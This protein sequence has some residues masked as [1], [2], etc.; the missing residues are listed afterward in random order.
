VAKKAIRYWHG[1]VQQALGCPVEPLQM[2]RVS[3]LETT[4]NVVDD[5]VGT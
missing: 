3:D 1:S 2:Q 4:R 5:L